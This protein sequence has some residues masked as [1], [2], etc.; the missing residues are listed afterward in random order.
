MEPTLVQA[1]MFVAH[2]P[3]AQ[4]ALEA[5][6]SCV[7]PD[8][9]LPV[10]EVL[11]AT[12]HTGVTRAKVVMVDGVISTLVVSRWGRDMGWEIGWETG[13]TDALCW[14]GTAWERTALDV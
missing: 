11:S 4:R 10:I 1:E 3:S 6:R 13:S 2:N 7:G 9:P 5:L 12:T 14:N 8:I